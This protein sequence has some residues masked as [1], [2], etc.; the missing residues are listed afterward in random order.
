LPWEAPTQN[1]IL[2]VF[3]CE[4]TFV[5]FDS[6]ITIGITYPFILASLSI[7][8]VV[9]FPPSLILV[10]NEFPQRLCRTQQIKKR[11]MLESPWKV[12]SIFKVG[13]IINTSLY[14]ARLTYMRNIFLHSSCNQV[15]MLY[16]FKE[17]KFELTCKYLHVRHAF[18]I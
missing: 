12:N 18:C 8:L 11:T 13:V 17:L 10:H 5:S 9:D 15:E 1:I 14:C 3:N 7:G 2:N 6:T 16:L 4:L